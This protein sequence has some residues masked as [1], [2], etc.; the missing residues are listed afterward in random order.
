MPRARC[1]PGP[2][3]EH[4][5]DVWPSSRQIRCS[6]GAEVWYNA[7]W[8]EVPVRAQPLGPAVAVMP[9][10]RHA[11]TGP[12][13]GS[14]WSP[15]QGDVESRLH[16]Y[17]HKIKREM[18]TWWGNEADEADLVKLRSALPLLGRKVQPQ[19]PG[20][21]GASGPRLGRDRI[22][23]TGRLARRPALPGNRGR[24]GRFAH[25]PAST[26]KRPG[27]QLPANRI[28]QRRATRKVRGWGDSQA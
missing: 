19:P 7:K 22:H 8:D 27:K 10:R 20:R 4:W 3:I 1:S 17:P 11:R 5:V 16:H 9:D 6:A 28:A 18:L 25:C 24:V 2:C 26:T 23:S 14:T 21:R 12:E 15:K 13:P